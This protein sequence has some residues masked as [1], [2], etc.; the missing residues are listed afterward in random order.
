MSIN[1]PTLESWRSSVVV[2]FGKLQSVFDW[3]EDHCT[4]DWTVIHS[5]K[6][7][8]KSAEEYTFEFSNQRDCIMFKLRWE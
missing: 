3:C 7:H 1:L 8:I 4:G 5:D 6:S 2:Q